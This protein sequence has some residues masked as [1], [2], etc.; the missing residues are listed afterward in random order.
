MDVLSYKAEGTVGG[1]VICK[2]KIVLKALK[3]NEMKYGNKK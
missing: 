2:E 1:G 3:W